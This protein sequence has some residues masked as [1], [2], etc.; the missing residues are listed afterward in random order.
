PRAMRRAIA[1]AL[2]ALALSPGASALA[3]P[4]AP[5]LLLSTTHS[6]RAGERV[7]FQG[8][9]SPA[10]AGGPVGVY[11]GNSLLVT[12]RTGVGGSFRASARVVTPGP[13]RARGG[14][15]V[16]KPVRVLILPVLQATLVG[17]R[18]VGRPLTLVAGLEPPTAGPIRV[19]VVRGGLQTFAGLF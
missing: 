3:P 1:L 4:A 15:L 10:R 14:G 12:G 7:V 19:R 2:L 8:Q 18:L 16:S 11:K 13:Y 6:A 17:P 9:L 5:A